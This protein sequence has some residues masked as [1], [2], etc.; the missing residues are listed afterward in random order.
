MKVSVTIKEINP[1]FDQ[2]YA[3]Q[4]H[5]GEESEDNIKYNWEDEL[6]VTSDVIEFKVLNNTTY[7][8]QG[9]SNDEPFRYDIPSMTVLECSHA[10]GS[11]TL[12]AASRKLISDTKKSVRK[13]GDIKFFLFLKGGKKHVNPIPGIYILKNDFP[14][15]LP[16]PEE[17]EIT[18]DE[19]E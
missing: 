18:G 7:T 10:D 17:D 8:L 3:N 1:G 13:N 11:K 14:E 15:T 16:E 12:F 4:H 5:D 6:E 9:F 2:E 19:E